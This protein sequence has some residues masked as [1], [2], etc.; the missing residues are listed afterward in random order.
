MYVH[1]HLFPVF[2]FAIVFCSIVVSC[3]GGSSVNPSE[4]GSVI[5]DSSANFGE[6]TYSAPVRDA[7]ISV[8]SG[9]DGSGLFDSAFDS[10]SQESEDADPIADSDPVNAS[11][12]GNTTTEACAY[13]LTDCTV[14]NASCQLAPGGTSYCGDGIR[15]ANE[16]CDDGNTETEACEYNAEYCTVCASD[17]TEVEGATSLC[18]DGVVDD[19]YEQ[20]DDE[21]L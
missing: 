16:Q 13:G 1:S 19:E 12:D 3:S 4:D 21:S 2:A 6:E 11:E 20:C 10:K 5:R 8:D 14:C 17:C 9:Q 18:G 7:S 15:N